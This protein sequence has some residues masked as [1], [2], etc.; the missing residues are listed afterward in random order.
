VPPSATRKPT[1]RGGGTSARPAT[2]TARAKLATAAVATLVVASILQDLENGEEPIYLRD[3][4]RQPYMPR[5]RGRKGQR[6]PLHWS[7]PYRWAT[8]GKDG[9]TL[10]T[11][12]TPS[13]AVVTRSAVLRFFSR[14]SSDNAPAAATPGQ[15]RREH[16]RAEAELEAAG[17]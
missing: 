14:L 10:E 13:G 2:S 4:P 11:L 17:I 9:V 5:G 8:A 12:Q 16:A 15:V 6:R 1:P 3:L 7:V